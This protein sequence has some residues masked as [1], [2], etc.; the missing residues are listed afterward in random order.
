MILLV[1]E[2]PVASISFWPR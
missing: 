2:V 1:G